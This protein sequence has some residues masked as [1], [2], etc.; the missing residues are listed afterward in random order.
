MAARDAVTLRSH[1][2]PAALLRD[3]PQGLLRAQIDVADAHLRARYD[4]A[5]ALFTIHDPLTCEARW[6]PEIAASR[7]W[8]LDTTLPVSLQRKVVSSV[9]RL[10]RLK[11]TIPGIIAAV[12]LFLGLEARV[13]ALWAGGWRLGHSRL[14]GLPATYTATGGETEV[15]VSLLVSAWRATP[16]MHAAR[17]WWNGVELARYRFFET[18]RTTVALLTRGTEYVAAGGE[19]S[20]TLPFTYAAGH[21]ALRVE[22][23]GLRVDQPAVWSETTGG[24]GDYDTLAFVSPLTRGDLVRVWCLEDVSPLSAGDEV[25]FR[26]TETGATRL[27]PTEGSDAAYTLVVELPR[28]LTTAERRALDA[29]LD[30]M[31][32]SYMRVSLRASE[33]APVRWRLGTSTLGRGTGLV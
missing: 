3:D 14:G 10:Y 5:T 15:D 23:N 33:T 30:V 7:G 13:R 24:S 6:L 25:V 21:N 4:D 1:G 2:I 18:S 31:K 27:A 22:K 16:H 20:L 19:T 26:T 11:G 9:T 17:V 32:P 29:I 28:A 8:Q 12:R